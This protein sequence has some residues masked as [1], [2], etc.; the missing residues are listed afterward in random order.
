M[1]ARLGMEP[2]FGFLGASPPG[3][4]LFM[5]HSC[6]T[7]D[8]ILNKMKIALKILLVASAMVLAGCA[9]GPSPEQVSAADYGAPMTQNQCEQIARRQIA[10]EAWKDPESLRVAFGFCGKGYVLGGKPTSYIPRGVVVYGYAIEGSV[11]AKNSFGGY[12]GPKPFFVLIRDG[13]V[14]DYLVDT[15]NL[16]SHVSPL[17][18]RPYRVAWPVRVE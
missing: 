2:H 1:R 16:S 18:G 9:T 8:Q 10:R 5:L 14:R 11:N 12:A 15:Y 6:N 13:V 17:S 3:R 7:T 4:F